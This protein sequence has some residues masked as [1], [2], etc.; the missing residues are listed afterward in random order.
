MSID[1]AAL[2]VKVS[3]LLDAES[4]LVKSGDFP[5]DYRM[6]GRRLYASLEFDL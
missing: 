4:Y 6:E 1:W 2:G 3:N 5:F